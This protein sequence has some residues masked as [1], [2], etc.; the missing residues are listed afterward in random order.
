MPENAPIRAQGRQSGEAE[1]ELLPAI[2]QE[3]PAAAPP[4]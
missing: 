3:S 1:L 2:S 4:A